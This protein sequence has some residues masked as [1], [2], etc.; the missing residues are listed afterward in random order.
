[1]RR[2]TRGKAQLGAGRLEAAMVFPFR[3]LRKGPF[4]FKEEGSS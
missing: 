3:V 1:M 4:T 2:T